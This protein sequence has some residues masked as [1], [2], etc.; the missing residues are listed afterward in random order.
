MYVYIHFPNLSFADIKMEL[1]QNLCYEQESNP[2]KARQ[3]RKNNFIRRNLMRRNEWM[4][5]TT[6]CEMSFEVAMRLAKKSYA[7]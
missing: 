5:S 6:E 3:L 7:M 1:Y 4:L 2:A